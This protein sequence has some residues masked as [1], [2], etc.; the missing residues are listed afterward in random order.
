MDA[1]DAEVESLRDLLRLSKE[2][3]NADLRG[4][5]Y[6]EMLESYCEA[7]DRYISLNLTQEQ[8]GAGIVKNDSVF[9]ELMQELVENHRVVLERASQAKEGVASDLA[10]LRRTKR[11][12]LAYL[13]QSV[14]TK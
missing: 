1:K 7:L 12:M 8:S 2:L 6:T 9:Y 5:L 4:E 14:D 13:S 10:K 3:A 11:G